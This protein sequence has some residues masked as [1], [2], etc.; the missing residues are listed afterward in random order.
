M[1]PPAPSTPPRRGRVWFLLAAVCGT[2]HAATSLMW[3]AGGDWL[4]ATAGGGAVAL[5]EDA[6]GSAAAALGAVGAVKLAAAWAPLLVERMPGRLRRLL[7]AAEWCAAVV[8]LAYGVV[9]H[10]LLS[11]VG[12]LG[13]FGAPEDPGAL[14]GHLLIWGPLFSLWAATLL[15]GLARSRLAGG[16]SRPSR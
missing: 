4:L 11:G 10:M 16:D 5:V 3:A 7:R 12:L 6:P 14:A 1:T 8:L 2:L 15:A 13:L 9:W